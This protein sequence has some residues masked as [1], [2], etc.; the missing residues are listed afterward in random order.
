MDGDEFYDGEESS[1]TDQEGKMVSVLLSSLT[2]V[3]LG[4]NLWIM[5]HA[6][7]IRPPHYLI[8]TSMGGH[9]THREIVECHFFSVFTSTWFLL[10]MRHYSIPYSASVHFLKDIIDTIYSIYRCLVVRHTILI[11]LLRHIEKCEKNQLIYVQREVWWED[12]WCVP[13]LQWPECRRLLHSGLTTVM[14]Q[15]FIHRTFTF[16]PFPSVPCVNY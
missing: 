11:A 3:T 10:C 7:L 12:I 8:Y 13:I 1:Q 5:Q 2:S 4:D 9:T 6:S 14:A 15:L 16:S